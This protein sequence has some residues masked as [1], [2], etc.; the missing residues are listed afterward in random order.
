MSDEEIT[1]VT[2][3]VKGMEEITGKKVFFLYPTASVQNQVIT[4]LT[5][6]EIE[7]YIAKDH[8]RLLRVLKKYNSSIVF[9]NIDESIQEAEWEKYI[10]TIRNTAPNVN[11]GIFSSS[12]DEE[13]KAKYIEKLK[14]TCGFMTLKLDMSR[15]GKKIM[16]ILGVMNVKGRRKYLR[17]SLERESTATMN[18]PFN[19]DFINSA[20]KDIS[21]VGI[22]V[23]FEHDPGLKKNALYKDMQIRL[24]SMLIKVEAVVFGSRENLGE[25]IYVLL[26]TQRID[27][28]VRVKIRKYIQSN[29]QSKMDS[30]IN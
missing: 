4:E 5:Q 28:D 17:A 13:L 15:A 6:H 16:D 12:S 9:I 11:V 27:P 22:S 29:L 18:M 8:M 26:F 20:I 10:L 30:E 14:I 23:V 21:V 2:A 25:K 24:Q 19:G 1:D 7:V 3:E